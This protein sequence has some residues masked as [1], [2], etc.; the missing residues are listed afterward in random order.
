MTDKENVQKYISIPK[1]TINIVPYQP[2]GTNLKVILII[3]QHNIK[4]VYTLFEKI[5]KKY[6]ISVKTVL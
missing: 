2:H 4:L 5:L 1:N 3:I 6:C